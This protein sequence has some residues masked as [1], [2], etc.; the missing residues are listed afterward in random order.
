MND[1]TP[2][3]DELISS[4]IDGEAT[5]DEVARIEADPALLARVQE[6]Q[7]A[8]DLLS[9]PVQP[10]PESDVDRLIDNAL[11]QSSTSDRVT[12]LAATRSNRSFNPQRLAAVAATLVLLAG[13][14]GAVIAFSSD[15]GDEMFASTTADDSAE[16][17]DDFF[18]DGD[19]MADDGDEFDH[20][21]DAP[22]YDSDAEE[23]AD[24]ALKAETTEAGE[25]DSHAEVGPAESDDMT[26][27][28]GP[29]GETAEDTAARMSYRPLELE[30]AE[31]YETLDA[32]IN[33]TA[34]QWRELVA[35][36]ATAIP[37]VIE[38]QEIAEQALAGAACGQILRD[39]IDT[40]DH[41]VGSGGISVGETIIA[42]SVTTV[43][44]VELSIDT[45]E[46]LAASEP[47]CEIVPLATLIG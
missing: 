15:S 11:T 17:A 26:A 7:A 20:P 25:P 13:V 31:R 32:L 18:G 46:L 44:V 23:L 27:E 19:D 16:M 4:Y 1:P 34:E 47:D 2:T 43:V 45:A 14:V 35:A 38:E 6:F 5:F 22:G 21:M 29:A 9:A 39:H 12:D 41:S 28:D 8:K 10:L 42:D 36:G 40:L 3:D 33:H 24:W 37:Q 30:I